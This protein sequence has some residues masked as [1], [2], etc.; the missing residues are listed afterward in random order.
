MYGKCRVIFNIANGVVTGISGGPEVSSHY[1]LETDY[2]YQI[3]YIPQ[4]NGS[5]ANKK[6]VDDNDATLLQEAKN[7]TDSQIQE[8]LGGEY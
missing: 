7:Y 2:D 4:Y 3:P 1:Y 8:T 5:P 6:Y